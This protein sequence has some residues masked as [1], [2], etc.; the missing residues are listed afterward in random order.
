MK[1]NLKFH[2]TAKFRPKL[3]LWRL[4]RYRVRLLERSIPP[5]G[6]LNGLSGPFPLL[7]TFTLTVLR[8]RR[9][10]RKSSD[11]L[12][13]RFT[14]DPK[15]SCVHILNGRH[16]HLTGILLVV[17]DSIWPNPRLLKHGT[18]TLWLPAI[19]APLKKLVEPRAVQLVGK[20][21]LLI[22]VST[23]RVPRVIKL[24]K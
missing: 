12:H 1:I 13:V 15:L 11:Y 19:A 16:R 8:C 3:H 17:L 22:C 9:Q 20:V 18:L 10:L 4:P 24:M 2:P 23:F 7:P 5:L 6:P 14:A 21:L